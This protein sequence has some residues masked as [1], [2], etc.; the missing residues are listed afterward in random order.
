MKPRLLTSLLAIFLLAS[1]SASAHRTEPAPTP[2]TAAATTAQAL[3]TGN[4]RFEAM[5][6]G[7][8]TAIH[9]TAEAE[10]ATATPAPTHPPEATTTATPALPAA[11]LSDTPRPAERLSPT[12][13]APAD[14]PAPLPTPAAPGW[15][16][17]PTALIL[18][19]WAPDAHP[20]AYAITNIIPPL[21]V[22]GDGHLIW[23]S[24]GTV[25]YQRQLMEGYLSPDQLSALLQRIVAAGF[26]GWKKFSWRIRIHRYLSYSCLYER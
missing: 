11:A 22:W 13:T 23:L 8:A 2:D 7:S 1:C 9:L 17:D 18:R 26:L 25:D 5:V 6:V 19:Y 14:T 15:E 21:Q 10:A 16:G 12:V 4:A 3:A 20:A 24:G